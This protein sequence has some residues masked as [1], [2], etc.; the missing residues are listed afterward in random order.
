MRVLLLVAAGWI[1]T[2]QGFSGLECK[3]RK[4]ALEYAKKIQPEWGP[5][6]QVFDALELIKCNETRPTGGYGRTKQWRAEPRDVEFFVDT[7]GDDV[8]HSGISAHAPFQ[9]L[10]RAVQEARKCP[11]GN[12]RIILRKGTHFLNQTIVL[13]HGDNNL[14]ITAFE[15]EK[16]WL[17]G[18]VKLDK[19]SWEKHKVQGRWNVWKSKVSVPDAVA[20]NFVGLFSHQPHNRFMRARYPNAKNME[21]RFS[22]RVAGNKEI[23]K[24]VAPPKI[25]G[26]TVIK[27]T[28][29][30]KK[31]DSLQSQYNQYRNGVCPGGPGDKNC[32]CGAW[33]DRAGPES[34][35]LDISQSYWCGGADI[36]GGWSE[37][38]KGFGVFNGPALPE[39]V[40]FKK[41]S[42]LFNRSKLWS[43]ATGSIVVAWRQ[44]GW[45]VNMFEVDTHKRDQGVIEWDRWSGG[46]QGGRG[47]QVS[48]KGEFDP[49]PPMYIENIFEE[50]DAPGEWYF[51]KHEKMLYLFH[52]R[53]GPP[54]NID[55]IVPRLTELIRVV[56]NSS[57]PVSNVKISNIGFRDTKIT[58]MTPWGVPSGGDWGLSR[59]G[60]I[61][62]EGT[63]DVEVSGNFFRR[64]D[65][66]GIMLSGYNRKTLIKGNEFSYLGDTAIGIWGFT[67]ENMGTNGEQPRDIDIIGNF[68]HDVG[69]S[70]LQSSMV[71][72]AKACNINMEK[73][74]FFNGPRSGI[75]FNDGFGGNNTVR[76]NLLFNLCRQS[77]DHGP[78]N[79][80]DRQIFF[81]DL[82]GFK[83][84]P[85][86]ISRNFIIANYGG[87]QGVD[88]DDGSA[89]Y[90]IHHNFFYGEGLKQDYGG[91]D[92]V[93]DSNLNVVHK[94]D[95]QNCV[96][97]W[98]FI[99]NHSHV[100]SNNKCIV[101]YTGE[102][103]QLSGCQKSKGQEP[104]ILLK[105]EYYT[106]DASAWIKCD[107]K[108][109]NLTTLQRAPFNLE[110][111]SSV[112]KIPEDEVILNWARQ[113]L[114]MSD[115]LHEQLVIDEFSIVQNNPAGAAPRKE[116]SQHKWT[117]LNSV[118]RVS[119]EYE[120]L[121]RSLV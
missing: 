68:G 83:S 4:L 55:F 35:R 90:N 46:W 77:G 64:L 61:F 69:I 95:G 21:D 18:G 88:N 113:N 96:N 2:A 28:Y 120:Q 40:V 42:E 49:V 5:H 31:H 99:S 3:I 67:E 121:F 29:D 20:D 7:R 11:T 19:L 56:G 74:I 32:S 100:F 98:A 114:L 118:S 93:Y 43:N 108:P 71:F 94:Y 110:K 53:T 41:D 103:G 104:T 101:L 34:T 112:S 86:E 75:N 78:I 12:K 102:L 115:H 91:H 10:F 109:I 79:S 17:S 63:K 107:G 87:S 25:G 48:K 1:S 59:T 62:L 82:A 72:Q 105:N 47:W 16:V 51:D 14:E 117:S 80:W 60:C 36:A 89:W 85:T 30:G 81:T 54:S 8:A 45:F 39:G 38:D 65:G 27:V 73:N 66:N 70:Q 58:Y 15:G 57:S 9:S 6:V 24:Y 44:Q 97:T 84:L 119:Q 13:G 26:G 22:V 23:E 76:N 50:L 116:L 106:P 111:D 33:Q 92:S 37:M 52:N